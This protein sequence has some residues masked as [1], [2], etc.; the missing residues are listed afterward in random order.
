MDK[1]TLVELTASIISSHSSTTSMTTEQLGA[2]ITTV[3]GILSNLAGGEA[4]PAATE[5][6]APKMSVKKSLG[7]DKI[8]CLICGKGFTTLKKHLKTSHDLEPKQYKKQFSIP[9]KTSLASKNYSETKRQTAVK[10]GLGAKLAEGRAKK[11]AKKVAPTT[12]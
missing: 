10:L 7:K 11:A 9:A 1:K 4:V 5:L 3:F 12:V 6:E 8:F 2:E